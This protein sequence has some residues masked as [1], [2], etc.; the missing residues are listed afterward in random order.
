VT[1]QPVTGQPLWHWLGERRA[2]RAVMV[3]RAADELGTQMLNVAIGWYVYSATHDPMSLAY[4][5]LAQFLPDVTLLLFAGQAADRF[6]R[7][8]IL[9]I[10]LAVQVACLGTFAFWSST[11]TPSGWLAYLLLIVVGAAHAFFS[12]AMSAILPHAV[13]DKDFPRA[14]AVT[15]SAFQICS[16]AGPAIGGALLA[17]G[18]PAMFAVATAGFLLALLQ[19]RHLPAN[20]PQA[21][22]G[23]PAAGDRSILAGLRYI[24]SN[25][26]LLGLIS[27]DLFAVLLGGVTALLPIYAHDILDVGP[28]G[29]GWLRCASG[30]GAAVVGL[31]LAHRTLRRRV[32]PLMFACVAGFG[33]ATIVFALSRNFWLSLGALAV[34]GGFDMV[35]VILRQTLVQL[36]TPDAMRGRVSAV[37]WLFIGASAQLGEFESGVVAALLGAVPAAVVGGVGTLAI[38]ALWALL[39]PEV[40]RA[41]RLPEKTGA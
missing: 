20:K 18:G 4:I 26:L 14:V 11:A 36:S 13:D 37:N 39:F 6:D 10:V 17:L 25:H 38:V 31:V 34:A 35:S 29:L 5:G 40:R 3:I 32:G 28:V 22:S 23:E 7:R 27:L 9:G 8:R 2:L 21:A 16:I 33:L 24:R 19:V 30:I 1:G 41:D 12:P 15:S